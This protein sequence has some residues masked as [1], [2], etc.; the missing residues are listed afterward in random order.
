MKRVSKCQKPKVHFKN[1]ATCL[2]RYI[3]SGTYFAHVRIHGKLFRE[4][5]HTD[6]RKTADRKLRD[7]RRDKEKV[8]HRFSR[9]T[10]ADLLNRYDQTIQRLAPA[11]GTE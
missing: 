9:S 8:D 1:V 3:P 2:Y 4:S 7:V 11:T 6:D 5:L 10:L